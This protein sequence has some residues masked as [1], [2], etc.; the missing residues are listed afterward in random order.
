MAALGPVEVY[1]TRLFPFDTLARMLSAGGSPLDKRELALVLPG[2]I[3]CR[4]R[5]FANGEQLRAAVQRTKPIRLEIGPVL[6]ISPA[7]RDTTE[8]TPVSKELVFDIDISD[9]DEVRFCCK[10]GAV[11]PKCW[12]L[13]SA[14]IKVLDRSLRRD[15]GYRHLLWVYSGR[16]GVHCWVCDP[17]A[18]VLSDT[19]RSALTESL[20]LVTHGQYKVDFEH[21]LPSVVHAAVILEPYFVSVCLEAQGMLDV[22]ERW[23]DVLSKVPSKEVRDLCEANWGK[24]KK[25]TSST[26]RWTQLK[27]DILRVAD[28]MDKEVAASALRA[29]VPLIIFSFVYPRLD[30]A[31]SKQ[32]GHLLKSPFSVHPSTGRVSVPIDPSRCDEFDPSAV[33][34][35]DGLLADII[36]SRQSS[37]APYLKMFS[38][39]VDTLYQ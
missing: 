35:T 22:P 36:N 8:V 12:P 26:E 19:A 31:V 6:D 20:S 38:D 21:A 32:M 39:F 27:D 1:Y 28:E 7:L 33:P 10:G 3:F 34:T 25:K 24:E 14:A 29:C 9:Y 30:A 2:H 11:C 5:S 15:F 4:N 17:S 16:R 37:L 13:V 18:R 23:C